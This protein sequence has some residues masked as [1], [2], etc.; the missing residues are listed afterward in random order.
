MYW[1]IESVKIKNSI[2]S[3][4]D[5]MFKVLL[6]DSIKPIDPDETNHWIE[7]WRWLFWDDKRWND[8]YLKKAINIICQMLTRW[9]NGWKKIGIRTI[10]SSQIQRR[11]TFW[12]ILKVLFLKKVP[13]IVIL[14]YILWVVSSANFYNYGKAF[15]LLLPSFIIK[16]NSLAVSNYFTTLPVN[17][18]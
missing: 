17:L 8:K 1:V 10:E 3:E 7:I 16:T 15:R 13:K 2:C 18:K 14:S 11:S 5:Q 6:D 12:D 9:N 4:F